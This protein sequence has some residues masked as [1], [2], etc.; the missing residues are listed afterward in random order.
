MPCER[1]LVD[2]AQLTVRFL[3][4]LAYWNPLVKNVACQKSGIVFTAQSSNQKTVAYRLYATIALY[5]GQIG[6]MMAE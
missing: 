3:E 6:M 5:F 1:E 4:P 2:R